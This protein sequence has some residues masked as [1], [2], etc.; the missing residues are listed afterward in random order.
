MSYKFGTPIQGEYVV[1]G[2]AFK[3]NG[4]SEPPAFCHNCGEP[5]PWTETR[6]DAARELTK[7]TEELDQDRDKLLES[8]PDLVADTPRTTLAATKGNIVPIETHP[9]SD[10]GNH[11]LYHYTVLSLELHA[12][13]ELLALFLPV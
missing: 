1:P 8:M 2:V 7:E 13:F 3:G 11:H 9:Q 12:V 5:F 6:L 10:P 4:P